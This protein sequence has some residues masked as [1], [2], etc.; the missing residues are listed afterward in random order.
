[1]LVEKGWEVLSLQCS[2][3]NRSEGLWAGCHTPRD[4]SL[5]PW[6]GVPGGHLAE[7]SCLWLVD[8]GRMPHAT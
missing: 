7:D 5:F 2:Y 4:L 8:V 3:G 6:H 1:M